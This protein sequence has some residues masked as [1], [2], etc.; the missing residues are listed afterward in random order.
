MRQRV[1]DCA[2]AVFQLRSISAKFLSQRQRS[3]VHE[4]CPSNLDHFHE[5]LAFGFQRIFQ[6]FDSGDG[7]FGK[8]FVRRDVHG[9]REGIVR[10][11]RLVYIVVRMQ[12]LFLIRQRTPFDYVSTVGN[13]LVRVHIALRAA[14]CLPYDQ[15]ELVAEFVGEN[16]V[17]NLSNKF[18]L[19]LRQHFQF[20]VGTR[21]RLFQVGESFDNFLWHTIDVACDF[22]ILDTALRLSAP[23]NV[24]GN[25]NLAHCVFFDSVFH[26]DSY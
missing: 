1:F 19:F 24:G 25:F 8:Q 22:E 20:G 15:W 13:H 4:M 17:A 9:G 21:S 7:F 2:Q 14:A 26:L 5:F 3:G 23:V 16:L 18:C 10:R 6:L 12:K 11:L